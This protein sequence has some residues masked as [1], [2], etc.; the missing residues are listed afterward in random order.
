M[1]RIGYGGA[2]ST[3]PSRRGRSC[4]ASRTDSAMAAAGGPTGGQRQSTALRQ[5]TMV[6]VVLVP[7]PS[8]PAHAA[9]PCAPFVAAPDDT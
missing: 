6:R 4:D 8:G 5:E 3:V 7:G 1:P 2:M 9:S